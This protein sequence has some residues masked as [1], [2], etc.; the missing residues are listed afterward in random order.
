MNHICNFKFSTGHVKNLET[1][2]I[3]FN[4]FS[5]LATNINISAYSQYKIINNIVY[6]FWSY[7]W[8]LVCILHL[9]KL[10][11]V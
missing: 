5:Y 10:N 3:N 11:S 7:H 1:D 6:S 9:Q 2:D 8:N 4:I